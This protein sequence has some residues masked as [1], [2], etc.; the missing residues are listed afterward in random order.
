MNN[1]KQ[2]EIMENENNLEL[3]KKSYNYI[4]NTVICQN[5]LLSKK[6]LYGDGTIFNNDF[7]IF[8][9]VYESIEELIYKNL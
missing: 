8:N 7:E 6:V 1:N 5:K 4:I 9:L 2:I 3:I